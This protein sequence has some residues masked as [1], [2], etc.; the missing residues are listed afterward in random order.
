VSRSHDID[1][2][3]IGAGPAGAVAAFCCAR[4]GASVLLVDRARFPRSKVCGCCVNERALET[5]RQHGLSNIVDRF[6]GNP[7]TTL[8][9]HAAGRTA[10]LPLHGG[11][12]VS[13][14]AIDAALVQAAIEAGAQFRD[15][16]SATVAADARVQLTGAD[17]GRV[18]KPGCVVV[19]DGLGGRSLAKHP[20]FTITESATGRMGL[21]ATLDDDDVPHGHV[22]MFCGRRGYVGM[23]RLEDGRL[24]VA[25][26]VDPAAL[27]A[28]ESPNALLADILRDAGVPSPRG[29]DTATCHG[30]PI[31]TR[32]RTP[33]AA[34]RVL[35][36]G[37]AAG[38]VEPFTGEG[39]AWAI[40]SGAG[41]A[42]DAV[43]A[44]ADWRPQIAEAWQRRYRA[45]I[46]RR[47]RSCR[48][49]AAALRRPLLLS[50]A[51]RLL[52]AAPSF[53]SPLVRHITRP[54]L[55]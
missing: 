46:G 1:V 47:Q 42:D 14:R 32:R 17:D 10:A 24:D 52:A 21:G 49:I 29:L 28:A 12:S 38:Y 36:V 51:V 20:A 8:Q 45:T 48:M 25:A 35:V 37:D 13:R 22:V 4:R 16:V 50:M 2:L 44:A 5:L 23:V 9:L 39:I 3:V 15:G 18:L 11:V 55:A 26:A 27:R 33:P 53:A 41:V 54:A 40:E 31:L 7:L 19:A 34:T 6:A 30:T 43:Q